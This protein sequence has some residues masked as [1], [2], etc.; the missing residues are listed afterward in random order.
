M[1]HHQIRSTADNTVLFEGRFESFKACLEQAVADRVALHC[2]NLRNQNLTNANLDDALMPGAD[3]SG[4]NLTGANMSESYLKGAN[5]K[6]AALYNT[7]FYDSNL[8]ACNFEDAAFGATD[9]HGTILSHAQFSTLS[10][11]SLDFVRAKAMSGCIFINPDGRVC[12]MSKP[13]IVVRGVGNAPIILLDNQIKAGHNVIDHKR[14]RP[15]LEKLSIR[16]VRKRIA[17]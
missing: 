9:I 1:Q 7:C 11:F 16:T 4:S 5:F 12:E 3:F 6:D 13:P 10:C 15:L 17:A 14:L 2:V 8:S